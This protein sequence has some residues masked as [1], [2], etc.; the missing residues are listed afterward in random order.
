MAW[1]VLVRKSLALYQITKRNE[2]LPPL[3]KWDEIHIQPFINFLPNLNR[4]GAIIK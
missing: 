3:L 1:R 4:D 2:M